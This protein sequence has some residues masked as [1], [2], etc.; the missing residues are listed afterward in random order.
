MSRTEKQA[1]LRPSALADRPLRVA[2]AAMLLLIAAAFAFLGQ[3][4][5]HA[6]P[7]Y[8]SKGV[9]V[10]GGIDLVVAGSLLATAVA[11]VAV[12]KRPSAASRLFIIAVFIVT[13][14][15]VLEGHFYSAGVSCACSGG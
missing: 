11:I 4:Y 6:E 8:A 10:S 1:P 3:H 5:V 7:R 12:V 15:L 13:A 9:Q 14:G 2:L